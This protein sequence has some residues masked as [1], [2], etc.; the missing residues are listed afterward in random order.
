MTPFTRIQLARTLLSGEFDPTAVLEI[1]ADAGED[2]RL[3]AM[4][5]IDQHLLES[6]EESELHSFEEAAI[7][8]VV[9]LLQ[10]QPV[11]AHF[12]RLLFFWDFKSK[13][14]PQDVRDLVELAQ[15]NRHIRVWK[16]TLERPSKN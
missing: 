15:A 11:A 7:A 6:E 13:L 14:E 2:I 12:G 10:G 1:L 3:V 5:F 16:A 9:P 8:M 4:S